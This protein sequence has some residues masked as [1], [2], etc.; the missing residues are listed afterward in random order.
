MNF[1]SKSTGSAAL[2]LAIVISLGATAGIG[3]YTFI[4]AKG[5]SYLSNNPA[6]CA[7]CHVMQEFYD[8]WEKS[9]H[10]SV[11]ACNDCHTP[12]N[13]VGKYTAKAT[14]GF[15]HSLAFTSGRFPDVI[16]IGA[17]NRAVTE[18]ACRSCHAPI[19]M[20]MDGP[21]PS[22]KVACLKCHASVG[23]M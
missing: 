14:N 12:R 1:K 20:A 3:A 9:S 23:H 11:A 13:F 19:V 8:G 18:A 22:G 17:R 5:Y 16:E 10:R 7:N 2:I 4:Y 21:H 15:F 6:A